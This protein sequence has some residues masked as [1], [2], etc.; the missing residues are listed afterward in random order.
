MDLG[1]VQ[2]VFISHLARRR[3]VRAPSSS[4]RGV[5][6]DRG[7]QKGLAVEEHEG[8]RVQHL[9]LVH[10]DDDAVVHLEPS[11]AQLDEGDVWQGRHTARFRG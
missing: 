2:T 5:A 11:V 3:F 9:L 10:A 6:L 7:P 4:L 1:R 8:L